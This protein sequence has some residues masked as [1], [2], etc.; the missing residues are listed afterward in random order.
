[1]PLSRGDNICNLQVA[2]EN[3]VPNL[4]VR[5]PEGEPQCAQSP[6]LGR[7]YFNAALND[8]GGGRTTIDQ[9]KHSLGLESTR[10]TVARAARRLSD[11]AMTCVD[12]STRLR[13]APLSLCWPFDQQLNRVISVTPPADR[14]QATTYGKLCPAAYRQS[15]VSRRPRCLLFQFD[16]Y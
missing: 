11:E 15:W 3:C 13:T 16:I 7:R 4:T 1:M 6:Y 2:A 5:A 14:R 12:K 10:A 8:L 9:H